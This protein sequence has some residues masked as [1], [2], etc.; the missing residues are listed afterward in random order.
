MEPYK[1]VTTVW[2]WNTN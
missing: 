2:L 1:N